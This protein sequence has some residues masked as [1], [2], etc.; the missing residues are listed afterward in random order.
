MNC[1]NK[2]RV[3]L[4]VFQD[5]KHANVTKKLLRLTALQKSLK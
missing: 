1:K 5:E 3:P 4:N 2:K